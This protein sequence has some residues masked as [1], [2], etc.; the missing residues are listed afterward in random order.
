VSVPP[1]GVRLLSFRCYAGR[2]MLLATS[3]HFSGGATDFTTLHWHDDGKYLD[4]VF[5][6]VANTNYMLRVL[7]PEPYGAA[8]VTVS[9]G[10]ATTSMDGRVL[11]I[12]F[13][14]PQTGPVQW[15]AAFP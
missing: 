10:P 7:V 4:G 12:G 8:N 11:S 2:P 15:S 6:G 13:A 3:R 5:N 9:C 1:H 14:C